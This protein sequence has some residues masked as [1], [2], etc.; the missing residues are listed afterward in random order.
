M[1]HVSALVVVALLQLLE[2]PPCRAQQTD[3]AGGRARGPD[4]EAP[5][6]PT[7]TT[8]ATIEHCVS[9]H[10]RA[11][12]L[13]LDEKWM[14]ARAAMGRCSTESCPLAI[15]SDCRVWLEEV[16]QAIPTLL[17]I[18]ERDDDGSRPVLM[19]L[20]GRPSELA[21]L[22]RPMEVLPGKHRLRFVLDSYA[23]IESEIVVQK[24]EKNRLVKVRFA[25][26]ASSP[27]SMSAAPVSPSSASPSPVPAS[28]LSPSPVSP[29]P[30]LVPLVGAAGPAVRSESSRPIPLSSYLLA[31][32]AL[33]AATTA[34]ALLVSAL[35][36]RGDARA[37]CA[38]VCGS[39]VRQAIETR[40]RFAD[41]SGGVG[42]V[43]G[44]LSAYTF[45]SRPVV[46]S[47]A[48]ASP[49]LVRAGAAVS[50]AVGF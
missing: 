28:P 19:E 33:L 30:P 20:D 14:E 49:S 46:Y 45:L 6:E 3:E 17:I 18:V 8:T 43:L 13:R 5:I 41:L 40:L 34:T 21:E 2:A 24:G 11:R 48:P 12:M 22:A 25:R 27:S 15:R 42:L 23:P 29:S 1:R 39:D 37:T 16:A 31:G 9:E 38:P 35:S 7:E 44:A 32:G 10:D 4:T 26:A 36:M 50:F 47:S